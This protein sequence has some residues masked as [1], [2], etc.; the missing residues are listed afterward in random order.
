MRLRP[1]YRLRLTF[2][3]RWSV[4]VAGEAGREDQV[5]TWG[6]GSAEGE[7]AG[8]FRATDY[9]RR[10]TDGTVLTDLRG[11]IE[12][13]DGTPILVE[14][15]GFG[16]R[17][18]AEY[19]RLSGGP[20]QWVVSVTHLSDS[21]KYRWL[22]DTLCVGTGHSPQRTGPN[23][24]ESPEFVLDVAELVWDPLQE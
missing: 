15:H 16:R 10:R 2:R 9:P 12:T 23:P 17:H 1:L 8:R 21:S 7:V 14:C 20:R 24:R 6:E 22:N 19:D 5:L 18:T 4:S 3:E 13:S 11:V